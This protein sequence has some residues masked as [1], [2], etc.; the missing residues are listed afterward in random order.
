MVKRS[1]RTKC[2]LWPRFRTAETNI[3]VEDSSSMKTLWSLLHI[4]MMGELPLL[5]Q[6]SI[7]NVIGPIQRTLFLH[8]MQRL[9]IN[10]TDC[11][12]M[13]ICLSYTHTQN[14]ASVTFTLLWT[15]LHYVRHLFYIYPAYLK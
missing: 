6:Y 2:C 14:P 12:L 1:R 3:I 11:L 4:V 9:L 5:F 10:T 13:I 7:I 8:N 15:F